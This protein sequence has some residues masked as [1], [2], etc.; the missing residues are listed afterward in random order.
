MGL[1]DFMSSRDSSSRVETTVTQ[2]SFNT[3][4]S[5]SNVY[6][7]LGNVNLT[8]GQGEPIDWAKLA[9]LLAIGAVVVGVGAIVWRGRR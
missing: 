6:D 8:I 2:D 9:P 4:R 7:N 1:F 5:E 3:T